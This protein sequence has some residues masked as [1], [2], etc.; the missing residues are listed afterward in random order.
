[1][2][3]RRP[4]EYDDDLGPGAKLFARWE[5]ERDVIRYAVLLLELVDSGWRPVALFDCSHDGHNDRHRYDRNGQKGPA[6]RFHHGSPGE[7]MRAAVE[8]IRTDYERMIQQW[9]R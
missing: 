3:P 6:E 2:P 8:L 7:A 5:T 9:R 1:M 4:H